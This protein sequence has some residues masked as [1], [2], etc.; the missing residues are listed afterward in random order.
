MTETNITTDLI[1]G[2]DTDIATYS[3]TAGAMRVH[4]AEAAE[5]IAIRAKDPDAIERSGR[6]RLEAQR[7]FAADY[8]GRFPPAGRNSSSDCSVRSTEYCASFGF[9]DRTVRRWAEKLLDPARFEVELQQRLVKVLKVWGMETAANYSSDS[10]EWYTPV[11]YLEAAREVLGE[12]DL[13]PASNEHANRSVR[14]KEFFDEQTNGLEQDWHGRV[15]MN[16]PYGRDEEYGSLAGAFCDKAMAEYESG[17]VEACIILVNS[18]HSQNWQAALYDYVVCFVDHRIQFV[19][20]DGEEN[21]NPTFQN[22][23]VYLGPDPDSFW[24]V[25]SKFGYVMRRHDPK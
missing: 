21:K 8:K 10:F 20:S 6:A 9:N 7:D 5:R 14:A 12:I 23:F 25:F 1:R 13:D 11:R 15:F 3:P 22:I 18:L 19:S 24:R 4:A 2:S 17:N 16:P